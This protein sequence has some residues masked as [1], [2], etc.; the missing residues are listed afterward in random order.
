MSQPSNNPVV[1]HLQLLL[2]AYGFN[3]YSDVNK[4]RADDLLVRQSAS[5]HLTA[6]NAVLTR[7]EA[8]YRRHFVPPSTREQPYPPA[9][10]MQAIREI[11]DLK[12]RIGDLDARLRGG[13]APTQ[14]KIWWRVRDEL[15]TLEA[16]LGYDRLI[17]EDAEH[18]QAA[19]S[20]LTATAWNTGGEARQS[21]D[22][23]LA[24]VE[25]TLQQRGALLQVG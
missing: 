1:Q 12:V 16:L 15:T 10:V 13:S 23:P 14:D 19:A 4:A 21:L 7:L 2:G 18:V 11:G 5:G 9:E 24:A 3:F 22:Q 20:A 25:S 17:I 8:D 6:A